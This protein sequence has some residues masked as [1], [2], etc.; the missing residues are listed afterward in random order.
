MIQPRH[1]IINIAKNLARGNEGAINHDHLQAQGA[2][3]LQLGLRANATGVFGNDDF[4][5]VVFQKRQIPSQIKRSARDNRMG[6]EH[7]QRM[8]G[9]VHQTQQI[10]VLRA[11]GKD[12][13]MLFSN[14]QKDLRGITWQGITGRLDIR[15]RLPIVTGSRLPRRAFETSQIDLRRR[16]STHGIGAHLGSKRVRGINHMGDVFGP[17]EIA[18]TVHPAKAANTCRQGLRDG[19]CRASGVGKQHVIIRVGQVMGQTRGLCGAAK[20]KDACH[21]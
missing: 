6:V 3:G 13:N 12:I 19:V 2:R 9:L 10:A 17:Q 18:Q 7:R 20:Q 5:V 8:G 15:N 4:D 16:A 14:R 1:H 21:V 11:R